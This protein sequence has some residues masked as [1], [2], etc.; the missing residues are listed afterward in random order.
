[1][2]RERL[3]AEG[4]AISTLGARLAV[5]QERVAEAAARSGRTADAVTLVG[6]CKTAD[7]A[8]IDEAYAAGLRHF[9]E[10]RVQDAAAKFGHDRPDDLTL[11]LIG[12]LQTNKARDAVRLFQVVHSADS[13]R[14]LEALEHQAARFGLTLPVLLEVNVS[15]EA[16]KQGIAPAAV[17]ALAAHAFRQPHLRPR[18]LMTVA[19][20]ADEAE[21]VRP[22][23]RGLRELR[24]RLV[25]AHPDWP[26]PDLSMGMT[27]DYTVAIE[28]GATLVRVGRAIFQ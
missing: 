5:V 3:E 25:A 21:A 4:M 14:L 24:D 27:N 22:V 19:P 11:H 16:S 2:T 28:E 17:E 1:V 7:R 6:V 9:G 12:H 8:A 20:L 10:N 23:F 15:G 13:E 18:G 26:L